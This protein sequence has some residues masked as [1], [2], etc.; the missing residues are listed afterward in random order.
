MPQIRCPNC[1]LTIN[2]ENRKDTDVNMITAAVHHNASTFT[3]LL[4]MTKLPRKTLCIRLKELCA[5]G[6]LAKAD[7]VYTLGGVVAP[8]RRYAN[9]LARISGAVHDK[10][11]RGFVMLGLLL[12]GFPAVSYVLATMVQF[13]GTPATYQEPQ[14]LGNFTAVIE[15]NNVKDLYAWQV[16]VSFDSNE[17][18]ILDAKTGDSFASEYPFFPEPAI[19]AD[20]ALLGATLNG[21]VPGVDIDGQGALAVITFGYYT[22]EYKAPQVVSSP[23]T[24]LLDSQGASIPLSDTTFSPFRLVP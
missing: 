9:P 16:A 11:M 17:L 19:R 1:G 5:S 12:I 2:L 18:K 3:D 4:R 15:V 14:L 21:E 24:F 22:S 8:E 6:V 20:G 10:R 23:E 7:G 13:S